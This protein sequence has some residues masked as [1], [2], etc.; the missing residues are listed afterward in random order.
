VTAID[1]DDETTFPP[2][3]QRAIANARALGF[4][5]RRDDQTVGHTASLPG[6]GR[7]LATLTAAAPPGAHVAE[8]GTAAGI[9]AAWIGGVLP[10]GAT[11]LTVEIDDAL[12]AAAQQLF[13]GEPRI[14]VVHGD[15][16]EVVSPRAP[17]D[18]VFVD[19]G[20]PISDALVDLVRVGGQLVVDD[21]TP[22][23][24]LPPDSPF[25]R[26]DAKRALFLGSP[27][28]LGVE[29]VLPDLRNSALVATR[30]Q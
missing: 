8:I 24:V 19:G 6:V 28:L 11:L 4:P 5:L 13:A 18:L 22:Q 29:V 17:F 20:L 1:L 7:L 9:G 16:N 21:V 15:A 30:V 14:T 12:A 10:D 26:D 25:L 2:L 3:V 27:R 23:R